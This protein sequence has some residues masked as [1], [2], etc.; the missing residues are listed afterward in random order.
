MGCGFGVGNS[1]GNGNAVSTGEP[2]SQV[3]GSSGRCAGGGLGVGINDD[4]SG[5][6]NYRP[7]IYQRLG[8]GLRLAVTDADIHHGY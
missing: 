5:G 8:G 7:L 2:D 6:G 4:I 1:N 3:L